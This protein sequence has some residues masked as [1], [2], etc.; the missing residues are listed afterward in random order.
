MKQKLSPTLIGVFVLGAVILGIVALVSFGS[1]NLFSTPDHFVV[2][3]DESVNGLDVGSA[4]K[5]RGVQ[6][7]KV[8]SISVSC[9]IQTRQSVV[10]VVC[11]VDRDVIAD[12]SGRTIKIPGK[13]MLPK[14]VDKGLRARLDLAGITGLRYVGL[15]FVDPAKSPPQY[16]PAW[17]TNKLAYEVV[18]AMPS[19]LSEMSDSLAEILSKWRKVDVAALTDD[20]KTLLHTANQELTGLEVKKLADKL[21]AAAQ[22]IESLAASPKIAEA[23]TNLNTS[24]LEVRT[25]VANIDAQVGSVGEEAKTTLRS[26]DSAAQGVQKFLGPQSGL[27]DETTRTLQQLAEASEA[28]RRLADFLERNPGALIRGKKL[29][30]TG[31]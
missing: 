27:S 25:L 12:H 30:E 11:E 8:R 28:V 20:L 10:G 24:I 2:Y 21:G 23:T 15:D 29:P 22:S 13:N 3:F 4:V 7:G 14:L 18:P 9:D 17:A 31:K 19:A 16:P 26:F 1:I 5:L 6:I